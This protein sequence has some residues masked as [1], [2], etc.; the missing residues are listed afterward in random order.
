M[1]LDVFTINTGVV[2]NDG[3]GNSIRDAFTIVNSN[4]SNIDHR[5]STGDY[6]VVYSSTYIQA[7]LGLTSLAWTNTHDLTVVGFANVTG[8]A[9]VAN[10][11]VDNSFITSLITATNNVA[12]HS[13][14]SV[15]GPATFANNVVINGNLTVLGNTTRVSSTDMS[16]TDSIISIHSTADGTPLITDDGKDVGIKF[17]YY[18]GTDRQAALVWAHDSHALEFYAIGT[19]NSANV[20]SGTYGNLKVGSLF[21][22]NTD[23]GLQT[24][25]N[26][27]APSF[28]GNLYGTHANVANLSVSGGVVGSMYFT[29]SDTVYINGSPVAT[30]ASSFLGG[31]VPNYSL[32]QSVLEA[33]GNIFANSG[34]AST[35]A[36]TGA[37]VIRGG[38]GITGDC[39]MTGNATLG[40]S[41]M[42][43]S[44]QGTPIGNVTP[45]TG[46]FTTLTTTGTLK[47]AG[48]IVAYSNTESYDIL[49]GALVVRGGAAVSGNLNVG[50]S[51]N[52]TPI[53]TYGSATGNFTTIGGITPGL[54]YFTGLK[55]SANVVAYSGTVSTNT[56]TGALV[57]VGGLGV[58][59]NINAGNINLNS[60]T[61]TATNL[62]GTFTGTAAINSGSINGSTNGAFATLTAT[63]FSTGNAV[64]TG[65][66][67]NVTSGNAALATLVATNFSTGNAQ[68][69]GG[70]V[71]G[72]S[73]TGITAL[74]P[75]G[76]ATVNLGS[77][78]NWWNTIYGV[79]SQAKYADLAENYL[80]DGTCSVASVV[81]F[82]GDAEITQ[83]TEFADTRVAGVISTAPAYLMNADYYQ[84]QPVAL[85]G[86]VPVNVVGKVAKGDLLV[87]SN[88]AGYATSVGRD[89]SYGVAVFAK[90]LNDKTDDA[91]GQ[92]EAVI[93]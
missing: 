14:L 12:F 59:G 17:N 87:T 56:T 35:S 69:T 57:V 80:G 45:S 36:T 15:S 6:G 68:I 33:T 54:G 25:G 46:A 60:G 3:T 26:V 19:E 49:T 24:V 28:N 91:P 58:G 85:R 77:A 18:Y 72:V 30:S 84:G 39:Y 21:A 81:I 31:T 90:S 37:I 16:V 51:I 50:G 5:I 7:N 55:A 47:A 2:A 4:F 1:S 88:V 34:V 8:N 63:N 27:N 93:L 53:G 32:F 41:M 40:G 22:A 10:L 52:N 67:I 76:N 66:S 71:S 13:N 11:L 79:A 86:R 83:C 20:F 43:A 44:L 75:A 9:H 65:G 64:I 78:A 92:I 29:G 73:L 89:G 48:N 38:L 62:V 61:V 23:I 70:A 42:M 82:G 74:T